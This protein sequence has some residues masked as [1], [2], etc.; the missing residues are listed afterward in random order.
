ML[1]VL[2]EPTLMTR[3]SLARAD[4]S[5]AGCVAVLNIGHWKTMAALVET[6][7]AGTGSFTF[8]NPDCGLGCP[9]S[10]PR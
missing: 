2:F 10:S 3:A 1:T 4:R 5:F 7:E 6:H 8:D 9:S